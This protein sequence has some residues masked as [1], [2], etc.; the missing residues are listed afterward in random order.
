VSAFVCFADPTSTFAGLADLLG[1]LFLVVGVCWMVRAFLERS[2][3]P[4]WW[5]GLVSGILMTI[6]AFWSSGQF[7]IHKAYLLLVF[8]G[9]WALLQGTTNIVRALEIRALREEL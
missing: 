4:L 8:A 7:F 2:I 5:M 1:F 6:L 3:N 9:I